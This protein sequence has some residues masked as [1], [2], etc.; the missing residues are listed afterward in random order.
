VDQAHLAIRGRLRK[1]LIRSGRRGDGKPKRS[2]EAHGTKQER[3][4]KWEYKTV[5]RLGGEERRPPRESL[6]TEYLWLRFQRKSGQPRSVKRLSPQERIR[7]R[8]LLAQ[9]VSNRDSG[10]KLDSCAEKKQRFNRK[11]TQGEKLVFEGARKNRRT[12]AH[13]QRYSE[14]FEMSSQVRQSINYS[15]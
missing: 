9:M 15:P 8:R 3:C 11:Q 10:R 5:L 14:Q 13:G 7:R 12:G 1:Q 2:E 4:I 6:R